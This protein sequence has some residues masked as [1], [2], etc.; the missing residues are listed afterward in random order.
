MPSQQ[1]RK[2]LAEMVTPQERTK[3]VS[4]GSPALP[5]LTRSACCAPGET[6][7]ALGRIFLSSPSKSQLLPRYPQGLGGGLRESAGVLCR[8]ALWGGCL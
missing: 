3:V 2:R 8:L 5:P 7:R 4:R 6:P 1:V